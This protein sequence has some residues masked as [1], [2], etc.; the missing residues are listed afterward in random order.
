[1]GG[2]G[3]GRKRI[4]QCGTTQGYHRHRR[5][6]ETACDACKRAIA[7][8]AKAKYKPKMRRKSSQQ[9]NKLQKKDLLLKCKLERG[10]CLMCKR[11]VTTENY[12]AFD[13]DHRDPSDKGF[14]I[15]QGW[16][17]RSI[18]TLLDEVA[19][20]DLLCAY[21]HRLRTFHDGHRFLQFEQN[22]TP[23]LFEDAS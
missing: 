17:G 15:S 1:M 3:S 5:R 16:S 14:T 22:M 13:W 11:A 2:K 10:C 23:N 7:D 20:C 19:K 12:F 8:Y 9:P 18:A 21:C 6:N 4:H